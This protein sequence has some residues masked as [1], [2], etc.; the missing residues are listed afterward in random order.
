[1]DS[2]FVTL[3]NI[4]NDL[5]REC[6]YSK[7]DFSRSDYV[8]FEDEYIY[9]IDVPGFSK[10]DIELEIKDKYM[11]IEGSV[12]V[13]GTKRKLSHKFT[14]S[15]DIIKTDINAEVINGMLLIHLPKG[16]KE[17]FKIKIK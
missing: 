16:K 17:N 15:R 4:E 3:K 9:Y 10:E 13:L 7:E 6:A 5:F 2:L 12:D 8:E 11:L 14:I 1:M